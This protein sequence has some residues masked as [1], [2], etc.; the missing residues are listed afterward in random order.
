MTV[1]TTSKGSQAFVPL[2]VFTRQVFLYHLDENDDGVAPKRL[3]YV[4]V[5]R[6]PHLLDLGG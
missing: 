5:P 6:T 1:R 3:C 2:K 4:T